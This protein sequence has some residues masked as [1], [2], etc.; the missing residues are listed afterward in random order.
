MGLWVLYLYF[1]SSCFLSIYSIYFYLYP[2]IYLSVFLCRLYG[3]SRWCNTT[4][5]EGELDSGTLCSGSLGQKALP[6]R[7]M[8]KCEYTNTNILKSSLLPSLLFLPF[9]APLLFSLSSFGLCLPHS[10]LDLKFNK[11]FV[12]F[13][14]FL[15]VF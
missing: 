14:S 9:F 1:T 2:F 10:Y 6:P 13:K 5:A 7:N 15:N 3:R 12:Y 4:P 11:F 8:Y